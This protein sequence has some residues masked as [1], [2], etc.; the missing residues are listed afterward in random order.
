M[1]DVVGHVLDHPEGVTT[2]DVAGSLGM[3]SDTASAYLGRALKA[4]RISRPRR[5]FYTP[6]GECWRCWNEDG[7]P[8]G[9][10]Q[11]NTPN[12]PP[13]GGSALFDLEPEWAPNDPA[14]W[15]R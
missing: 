8:P 5:G 12:T 3:D 15:T 11:T 7:D 13:G 1:A 4:G 14:R 2:A 9:S 10:Q 6:V